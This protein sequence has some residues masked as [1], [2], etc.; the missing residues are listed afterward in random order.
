[1]FTFSI[2]SDVTGATIS[3][4]SSSMD[5]ITQLMSKLTEV[6]DDVEDDVINDCEEVE[7]IGGVD[8]DDIEFDDEDYAWTYDEDY[9]AWFWFD[10]E[11]EEWVEYEDEEEESEEESEEE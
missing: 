3:F 10:D 6:M 4:R 5:I 9:G 7:E 11:N 8:I 2:E 1:M